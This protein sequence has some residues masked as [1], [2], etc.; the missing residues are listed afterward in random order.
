MRTVGQFVCLPPGETE[1]R[2]GREAGLLRQLILSDDPL[3][4]QPLVLKEKVA[5]RRRLDTPLVDLALLVP[6][7]GELLETEA[8]RV[9][10]ERAVISGLTLILRTEDG[11]ESS[12]LIRPAAP[13]LNTAVLLR[14][15][16]LRLS[17]RRLA[18]G[19]QDIEIRC[20]RVRPSRKQE[21]LFC[22]RSRDLQAGAR[23]FA[24]IRARFGNGAVAFARLDDSHLPEH[25][26]RWAPLPRR[27]CRH[28]GPRR[29]GSFP[30]RSEG[31]SF[32]RGLL[33][34][35]SRTSPI[36]G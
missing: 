17:E 15:V 28:R 9:R 35:M 5:C 7:I 12:D 30:P 4:I 10:E 26:F 29:A 21:E 36:A 18:S 34:R 13:T 6:H 14:L 33:V 2:L 16:Q 11:E 27:S 3:P 24:A 20:A 8:A 19:V 32:P 22:S 23:A 31:S 25:S 1:R